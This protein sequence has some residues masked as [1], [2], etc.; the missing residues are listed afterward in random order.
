LVNA[1]VNREGARRN[2]NLLKRILKEMA[3]CLV[4]GSLKKKEAR[5][6]KST[7]YQSLNQCITLKLP[8]S[9][10]ISQ[11]MDQLFSFFKS[12]FRSNLEVL[13]EYQLRKD[14]KSSIG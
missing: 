2:D 9:T 4:C 3:D 12:I 6:N 5:R 1:I 7:T 14:G 11:E 10:H 8:N 13:T